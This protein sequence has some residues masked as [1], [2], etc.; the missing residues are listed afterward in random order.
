MQVSKNPEIKMKLNAID[1]AVEFLNIMKN[2]KS[3][4]T[5]R[6][7]GEALSI[8]NELEEWGWLD[9][10]PIEEEKNEWMYVHMLSMTQFRHMKWAK[11]HPVKKKKS[12]W[13]FVH[14][15]KQE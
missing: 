6:I 9:K 4:P 8:Y 7:E 10:F 1:H 12:K 13:E 14:G 2:A 5:T 15:R 11:S 3:D